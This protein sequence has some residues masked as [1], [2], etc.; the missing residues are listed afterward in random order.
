[1]VLAIVLTVLTLW[2]LAALVLAFVTGSVIHEREE[3]DRPFG[4]GR[5][6]ERAVRRHVL[7]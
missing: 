1:M 7:N 3:H 6:S 5:Y 4:G 2:V